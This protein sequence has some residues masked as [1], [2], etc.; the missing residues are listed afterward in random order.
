MTM[1]KTKN[2][3]VMIRTN[4]IWKSM[5]M[6]LCMAGLAACSNKDE[7]GKG[8]NQPFSLNLSA[9]IVPQ[10]TA[11]I[12]RGDGTA[13]N[14]VAMN[15]PDNTPFSL[16]YQKTGEED[17]WCSNNIIVTENGYSITGYG[18][19]DYTYGTGKGCVLKAESDG[20]TT[21]TIAVPRT[22]GMEGN[23]DVPF[24][25]LLGCSIESPTP[26]AVDL[27]AQI[28]SFN[29]PLTIKTAGIRI[30]LAFAPEL[31][32]AGYT[33]TIKGFEPRIG[34]LNTV[35]GE[36]TVERKESLAA[37]SSAIIGSITPA[38]YTKGTAIGIVTVE[39]KNATE[40]TTDVRRLQV[41][42]PADL[43]T[44][45]GQLYIYSVSI[46]RN[47]ALAASSVTIANFEAANGESG[48]EIVQG[49]IPLTYDLSALTDATAIKA[50]VA[51]I[52]A[53]IN[54]IKSQSQVSLTIKGLKDV[55]EGAFNYCA[56]LVYVDLP[57]AITLNDYAFDECSYLKSIKIASATTIGNYAFRGCE[58]LIQAEMSQVRTIGVEAFYQCN[59]L[60]NVDLPSAITIGDDAFFAC[61]LGQ[62]ILPMAT[63]I[64][65]YAFYA[66]PNLYYAYLPKVT[67][68]GDFV[69]AQCYR[70][71]RIKLTAAGTIQLASNSLAGFT[72][73]NC[74]L[75]LNKDKN[76][77]SVTPAATDKSC[78]GYTW[79]SITFE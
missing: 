44:A 75:I 8:S 64:G 57:D 3:K 51:E 37:T 55:P 79:K 4:I 11:T 42:L 25:T 65:N 9:T 58:K 54:A 28:V 72:T 63:T 70:I 46:N 2:N 50:K 38:T 12:S 68:I 35:Y 56:N 66:N 1:N 76:G 5:A 29:L 78:G 47:E 62:A 69:F 17:T 27:E 15:I 36:G 59:K 6:V 7:L 21:A 53:R 18:L 52:K 24:K 45:A 60:S 67:S 43:T 10:G 26:T 41:S 61:N 31:A 16:S 20:T 40:G 71:S 73:S 32:K 23:Y 74:D 33:C 39:F 14:T 13:A 30:N 49:N 77:G 48:E 22:D 19:K 34:E